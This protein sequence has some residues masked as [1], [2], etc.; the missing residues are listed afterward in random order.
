MTKLVLSDGAKTVVRKLTENGYKAYAVGGCVR[1]LLRGKTPDDYDIATSAL[2][3]RVAEVFSAY[4]V[5][6]TGLKH[7]TVTVVIDKRPY[8]ITTFRKDGEYLDGR[9]PEKVDFVSDIE[10][11]LSRRDFT[12]NAMAYNDD[13]GLIDPF[14]GENDLKNKILRCVGDPEKRFS[15]DALRILRAA[16]FC[17]TLSFTVEA[18]TAR[19]A[20]KLAYKL[21]NV[22]AE[23][24]F[25]ETNKL[26]LGDNAVGALLKF[27]KVIFEIIPE[28]APCDGFKQRTPWHRYDVYGHIA[29]SVGFAA[30]DEAERWCMLLHDV[31][32]PSTFSFS[33]G[34]GHFYGHAKVSA[35]MSVA[36]FARLK[37]PSALK[38]EVAF[39]IENHG[40]PLKNDERYIKRTMFKFGDKAFFKLLDVHEADNMAQGTTLSENERKLVEEVRKTAEGIV[41]RG[42]CYSYSGLKINGSDLV[43]IGFKGEEVGKTLNKI[44]IDVIEGK[45]PDE[46][47]V[48]LK[49]AEKA[50]ARK[51]A[52]KSR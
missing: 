29:R 35:D 26:L 45:T 28:L 47:E 15:E 38:K 25:T 7:G 22:S 42:V 20:V 36:V 27:R 23:R 18:E 17:S 12:V 40:Y 48:L 44:L 8:E 3:E 16:R 9:R 43:A 21:K 30:R 33:D 5:I 2:P 31:G 41:K 4:D 52:G 49:K 39:L 6:P 10:E 32:K 37:F 46:R 13:E 19:K 14:G 34:K 51:E 11:D 24:I 50:Y 1:D